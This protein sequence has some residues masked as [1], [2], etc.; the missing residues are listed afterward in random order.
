MIFFNDRAT[1]LVYLLRGLLFGWVYPLS[2]I[3]H[4]GDLLVAVV[5]HV[6]HGGK[7]EA[8]PMVPT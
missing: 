6:R 5:E 3:S 2:L 4:P 1:V 7:P 8:V